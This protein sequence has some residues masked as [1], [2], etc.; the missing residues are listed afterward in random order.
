MR[1]TRAIV[2]VMVSM[3]VTFGVLSTTVASADPDMYHNGSISS[4][5]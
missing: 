2:A 3:L 4:N 5:G 1:I